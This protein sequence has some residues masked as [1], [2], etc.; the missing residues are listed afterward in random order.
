MVKNYFLFS[1]TFLSPV[2]IG[3][4]KLDDLQNVF[5][6]TFRIKLTQNMATLPQFPDGH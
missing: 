1:E 3:W 5:T 6:I 4:V 2:S